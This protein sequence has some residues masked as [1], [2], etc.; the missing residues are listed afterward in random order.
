MRLPGLPECSIV[1]AA[2]VG[3]FWLLVLPGCAQHRSPA[4]QPSDAELCASLQDVV[5]QADDR[6]EKLKSTATIGPFSGATKWETK[7]VFPESQCDVIE[8]GGGRINYVCIWRQGEE[9]QAREIYRKNASLI[10][11]CLGDTWLRSDVSAR[12]GLGT[13]FEKAGTKAKVVMRYFR[14]RAG[15]SSAWET[16][17]TIGD[18]V[19]PDAR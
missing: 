11:R 18:E 12:T 8:W 14:P 6:F 16:S 17:L 13:S 2:A 1:R 7:P 10:G 5:A 15:Y 4:A 19:T 9:S 3:S